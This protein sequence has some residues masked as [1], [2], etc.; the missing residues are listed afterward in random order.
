M[1]IVRESPPKPQAKG[2]R[3]VKGWESSEKAH[4][5]PRQKGEGWTKDGLR[6]GNSPVHVRFLKIRHGR[7]QNRPSTQQ[8][9]LAG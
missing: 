7:K 4:P 6:V 9:D 2:V 8:V 3:V 5:N 1:G